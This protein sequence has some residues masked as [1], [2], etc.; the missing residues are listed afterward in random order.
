MIEDYVL[1][2]EDKE[3]YVLKDIKNGQL[4]T[5]YKI[6][7]SKIDNQIKNELRKIRQCISK[8]EIDELL[9]KLTLFRNG[10]DVRDWYDSALILS[11][12]IK[13]LYDKIGSPNIF[14][15]SIKQI[16]P[17]IYGSVKTF[18]KECDILIDIV[19]KVREID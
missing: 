6:D 11:N 5:I 18:Y 9:S 1:H 16:S 2:S 7:K 8:V 12:M 10:L 19:N 15:Y 13:K 3:T 17:K 14:H 4:K